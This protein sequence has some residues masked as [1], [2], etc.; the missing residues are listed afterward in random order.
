MVP[1]TTFHRLD[2]FLRRLGFERLPRRGKGSHTRYRHPDGRT[3]TL[4]NHPGDIDPGLIRALLSQISV[5][6]DDYLALR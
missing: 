5:S 1:P 3:A 2:R 6:R 4:P